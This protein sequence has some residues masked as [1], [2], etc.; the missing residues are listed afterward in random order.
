MKSFRPIWLSLFFVV[1]L[2]PFFSSAL[3]A[4]P[5]KARF[6][7]EYESWMQNGQM[8]YDSGEYGNALLCFFKANRLN[9]NEEVRAMITKVKSHLETAGKSGKFP[10]KPIPVS[11]E[12]SASPHK[13][14]EFK[15]PEDNA[16][17]GVKRIQFFRRNYGFFLFPEYT[18]NLSEGQYFDITEKHNSQQAAKVEDSQ[19]NELLETL[20][21]KVK[22]EDAIEEKAMEKETASSETANVGE[23]ADTIK[24]F[25]VDDLPETYAFDKGQVILRKGKRH[26][27]MVALTF[28]DGPHPSYTPKLLKILKDN[29][30]KA[31][32]FVLGS[33]IAEYQKIAA[34]IH[35]EGHLIGNHSYSH[36]FYKKISH[37]KIDK[38]VSK[39]NDIIKKTTGVKKIRYYRPPYGSLP[40]YFIS[41]AEEEGFYIVMWSL[42]SKDYQGHSADYTLDKVLKHVRG[43]DVMLFHDIHATTLQVIEELIPILKKAGYKFVLLDEIYGID[44]QEQKSTA[45]VNLASKNSAEI[46]ILKVQTTSETNMALKSDGK[47]SG[48]DSDKQ[49]QIG[50][51]K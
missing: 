24:E 23:A 38:E 11:D 16:K 34:Q 33:R 30:V 47:S 36:P 25:F 45:E 4:G 46:N 19:K 12:R 6:E 51:T 17:T 7:K 3:T 28:D 1:L 49:K 10:L 20:K 42:D 22:A 15:A 40:K 27:K 43:G 32:F 37:E 14:N 9:S 21:N 13:N 31:T 26:G 29:D 2:I 35:K 48:H 5:L 39:T 8:H 18:M 41:K 44:E 50:S